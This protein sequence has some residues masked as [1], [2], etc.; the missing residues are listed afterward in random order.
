MA[1]SLK[2]EQVTPFIKVVERG[3]YPLEQKHCDVQKTAIAAGHAL[4]SI[5]FKNYCINDLHAG[6]SLNSHIDYQRFFAR[7][8]INASNRL[9][10]LVKGSEVVC[11]VVNEL[12]YICNDIIGLAPTTNFTSGRS[13]PS[14]YLVE[15][16]FV[17]PDRQLLPE[18]SLTPLY[19]SKGKVNE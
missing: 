2:L 11:G 15:L 4:A 7:L 8:A 17:K 9:A 14:A 1:S 13:T 3:N 19:H 16:R 18:L 6:Y 12:T 5:E 10:F